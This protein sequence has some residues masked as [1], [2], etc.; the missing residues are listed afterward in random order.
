MPVLLY[1][2]KAERNCEFAFE[3]R[4]VIGRGPSCDLRLDDEHASR[5]HAMVYEEAGAFF[6]K[7]LESR[8]GTRLNGEKVLFAHLGY[9]DEI[10]VGHT[11]L[12]FVQTAPSAMVGA[13]VGGYKLL[14]L[15]G[16]GG[17][18]I[19]FRARRP[20]LK[21]DVALKVLHPRRASDEKLARQF[22]EQAQATARLFH[23][24]LVNVQ[25][26]GRDRLGCYYAM[27]LV[28][29]PSAARVLRRLGALKPIEA[30]ELIIQMANALAHIHS[31][32]LVH[33]DV[34]P[35][36]FLIARDATAKLGDLALARPTPAGP[37]TPDFLPNGREYVWGTPAYMS[38]EVATGHPPT[39]AS[40]LY[41]LGASFFHL[42]VG[43]A[44]F[45]GSTTDE[46]L[47]RHVS[48]P[49]PDLRALR[50]DLPEGIAAAI[51]R[52]MAKAPERRHASAEDL[53]AE[54]RTIR[55]ELRGD[56][57]A[58]PL[59]SLLDRWHGAAR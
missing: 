37:R 40:D 35:A 19:V 7:D 18:G 8:N 13:T 2:D 50:K 55:E 1:A 41:S 3:K 34:K 44:P 21:E 30:L 31:H 4:V 12:F 52:L 33:C 47:G 43:K 51:E 49:L 16:A 45:S 14:E 25:D 5:T 42:V 17:M 59:K 57:S 15:L 11:R 28:E 20:G 38:P 6:L 53:L 48:E 29:G 54:L 23:P 10:R 27:E 56:Q 22:V 39:P 46:V 26:A 9:G 24:N 32:D 58:E 36:N